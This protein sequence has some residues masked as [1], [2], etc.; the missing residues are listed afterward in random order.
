LKD[1]VSGGKITSEAATAQK[2][3]DRDFLLVGFTH[4]SAR[5]EP[6]RS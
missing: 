5:N 1:E 4:E 6:A 3:L 2:R